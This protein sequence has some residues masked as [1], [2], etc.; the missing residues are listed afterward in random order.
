MAKEIGRKGDVLL[1]PAA[2]ELISELQRLGVPE[3]AIAFFL[4]FE[5]KQCAD[6]DGVRLWPVEEVLRENRD[7]YIVFATTVFGDAFC[8]DANA[9]DRRQMPIVLI[10]HDGYD[11][12]AVTVEEIARLKK[13]IAPHFIAFLQAY[14]DGKLDIEPNY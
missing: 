14:V 11:W 12:D 6:I 8:F 5:P 3:D 9:G 4:E 1:G 2:P 13:P 7:G 10:S